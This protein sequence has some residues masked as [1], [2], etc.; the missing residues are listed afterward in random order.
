MMSHSR[1]ISI[2]IFESMSNLSRS[3]KKA[4]TA[5]WGATAGAMWID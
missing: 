5:V 1:D 4:P 3:S 2:S